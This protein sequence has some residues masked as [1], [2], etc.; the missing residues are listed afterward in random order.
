VQETLAKMQSG[1]MTRFDVFAGPINNNKGE[2]VIPAGEK[3]TQSDLEGIDEAVGEQTGR[4]PCT[5]CMNWLAEGV[6][7]DAEL[8]Q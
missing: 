6:A 2:E 5:F 1:E 3:L 7:P 8:P 4:E